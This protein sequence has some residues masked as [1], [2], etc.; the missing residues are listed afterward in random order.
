MRGNVVPTGLST[1]KSLQQ[2]AHE[3]R[4]HRWEVSTTGFDPNL[5]LV[6]SDPNGSPYAIGLQIPSE[7][8]TGSSKRYLALLAVAR[9]NA[10]QRA[11]LVGMRQ[12][13]TLVANIP[14][15]NNPPASYPLEQRV[16]SPWWSFTDGNVEW[17]LRW[18]PKSPMDTNNPQNGEGLQ[19]LYGTT[20]AFLYNAI[21]IDGTPI[22][23]NGG[24]A[25]GEPLV[26]EYGGFRDIRS[27]WE[28]PI[29]MDA[30]IEGP[31]DVAIFASIK[32]TDPRNRVQLVNALPGGIVLTTSG[33]TV[34]DAFVANYSPPIHPTSSGVRYG[35]IAASLIFEDMTSSASRPETMPCPDQPASA[36]PYTTERGQ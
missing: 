12:L 26:A 35:R 1:S 17:L 21:A 25:P 24:N 32:Q 28:N 8:V 19:F 6:G 16:L 5:Q 10:N 33:V 27:P 11:R 18:V 14:D 31:G 4:G 7:P 22:P 3:S 29:P 23:P 15:P 9:F 34:E 13:L 36:S 2:V 20:P 30:D